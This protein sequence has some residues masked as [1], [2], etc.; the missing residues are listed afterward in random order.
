MKD[1]TQAFMRVLLNTNC[2]ED[3]VKAIVQMFWNQPEKMDRLVDY[4]KEHH[5]A[6]KS[7]ILK[8]A[9]RISEGL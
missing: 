2:R 8:E 1:T 5:D 3:T 6:S 7:E 4:L 9:I